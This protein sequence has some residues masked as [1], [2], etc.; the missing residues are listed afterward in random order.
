[1]KENIIEKINILFDKLIVNENDNQNLLEI[2]T[3]LQGEILFNIFSSLIALEYLHNILF[4]HFEQIP[5]IYADIISATNNP[6]CSCRERVFS[7]FNKNFDLS[8][9]IFIEI[10]KNNKI[11]YEELEAIYEMIESNIQ[12]INNIDY[13]DIVGK[14]FE[15]NDN[16]QDYFNFIQKLISVNSIYQGISI[17]KENNKLKLYFY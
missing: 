16:E 9:N 11:S 8:K 13:V 1:M 4:S 15:I 7:F 3:S 10:F 6:N 5:E 14:I 2:K 12:K 17:L